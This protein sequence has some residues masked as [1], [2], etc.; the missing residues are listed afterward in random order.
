V[1]VIMIEYRGKR[2]VASLGYNPEAEV[3]DWVRDIM[4]EDEAFDIRIYSKEMTQEE[5]DSFPEF[6]GY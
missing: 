4:R 1:N 6:E 5:I 3:L 2:V